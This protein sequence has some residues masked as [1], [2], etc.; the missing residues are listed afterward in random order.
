[1]SHIHDK[2]GQHD[3]TVSAYIIRTDFDEPKALLHLHKKTGLWL[4]IGGHI[5][6][7]ETP[8]QALEREI[9]EESGYEIR[10]LELLQPKERMRTLGRGVLHP[11]A[12]SHN[13]HPY[14]GDPGHYHSDLMYAFVAND[15]PL[16]PIGED[17]SSVQYWVGR[18][19]LGDAKYSQVKD[20]IIFILNVCLPTW[21]RVSP[22][23]FK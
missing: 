13:T 9:L 12:I 15:K 16:H 5:E 3:H 1:M 19:E 2:F 14:G 21:E 22:D 23:Q 10:Q 20:E 17:E 7:D 8:W 4:H 18:S 11:Q 6:L